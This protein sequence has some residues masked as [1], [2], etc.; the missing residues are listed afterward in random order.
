[1]AINKNNQLK[2]L[3]CCYTAGTGGGK[4]VAV[5]Y[6]EMMP[7]SPCLAI[8]DP[9]GDYVYQTGSKLDIGFA[10]KRVYH[11]SS[12]KAFAIAFFDAWGTKRPFRIAYKPAKPSRTEML[13]FC[14]LMWHAADGTRRLDVVIEEVA[15]WCDTT[16]KEQS[17]LG[18]CLTGG[19]KFGLVIHTVF[20]RSTEVPKTV[21]SQSPYKIIG[22]Q[23]A[24]ADA[25]RMAEECSIEIEQIAAL[26]PLTYIKKLPGWGNVEQLDLRNV[27]N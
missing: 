19:R 1:M 4:S 6:A 8:F 5:Q 13:W 7:K 2:A 21:L 22:I 16:G 10:G 24:K 26:E 18:E 15:K 27:F 20:Q 9:Y 25:K 23:E 11:Y 14:E 17:A 3:H 12:R